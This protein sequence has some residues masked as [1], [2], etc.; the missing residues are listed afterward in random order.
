[1]AGAMSFPC[2]LIPSLVFAGLAPQSAVAQDL[3]TNTAK[4]ERILNANILPFWYP[5]CL[6]REDGGYKLNHDPQGKWLGPAPKALVTQART[7]WFFSRLAAS[8][9]GKPAYVDAARHGFEFLRDRMWD[10]KN[11]G[12][13]WLVDSPGTKALDPDKHLY[14]QAFAL[15][16]LSE[17]YAASRDSEALQLAHRL[18]ELVDLHAHD[19]VYGGYHESFSRDWTPIDDAK[20]SQIGTPNDTKSMNTHLHLMEAVAR[21]YEV[22]REPLVRE[23]LRELIMILSNAVLRKQVGVCTDQHHRNWLPL[24]GPEK[25]IVSY[26]HNIENIWLLMQATGSASVS[27]GPLLDLYVT[28]FGYALDYGYDREQGGFFYTGGF[29]TPAGDR[30]K[31]WWVQAEGLVSALRM[32]RRTGDPIYRTVFEQTLD[33]I[34]KHQVDWKHG[35]WFSWIGTDG[36]PSGMKADPWKGPYHDGRAV[37]ECLR[38]LA[39]K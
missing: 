15:Y 30:R 14:G 1:M 33:W 38:L 25:S 21:Y 34:V 8:P 18:F 29:G 10:Q 3:Q 35:E 37:L 24:L 31:S 20:P 17:Y 5:G 32:Y 28:L 13:Y 23:R 9:Y 39:E 11:G 22:S 19:A 16:A 7:V 4:L 12:L 27:D 2:F 36:R 6:D 26:G